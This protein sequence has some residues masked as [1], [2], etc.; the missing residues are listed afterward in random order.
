M[1]RSYELILDN[2]SMLVFVGRNGSGKSFALNS[3]LEHY[4]HNSLYISEEGIP[5][6]LHPKNSVQIYNDKYIYT[7]EKLR[8]VGKTETEEYEI[9]S[10]SL[11]II[12]YCRTVLKEIDKVKNKSQGQKKMASILKIFLSYNFNNI[13]YILFDE[14][15]NFLDE[16]YLRVVARLIQKL[17]D[18]QFK[19]RIATHNSTLMVLL[20]INVIDIRFF[21][22]REIITITHQ[23]MKDL[24][25]KSK[26]M[27]EHKRLIEKLDEDSSIAYKLKIY[28]NEDLFC[29]YIDSHIK[30]IE[31][32]QTIFYPNIIIVEGISDKQALK[33]IYHAFNETTILFV[34]DGKA[35][36]IFFV[37]LFNELKKDI[38]VIIDEDKDNHMLA[39]TYVLQAMKNIKLIIHTPDM[40]GEYGLDLRAVA[41]RYGMSNKVRKNNNGWLKQIAAYDYFKDD[42]NQTKLLDKV[43]HID[44]DEYEFS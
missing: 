3:I 6:V 4:K 11:D 18:G 17:Q 16:S 5:K 14:P 39:I 30:D 23:K 32:Y 36:I 9:D 7:D 35:W 42:V 2:S 28:E 41:D 24:L 12:E 27:I 10:R 8:G 22:D 34:T 43:F 13:D 25:K 20:N 29:N 31:F 40:E 1:S 37:L 33:S 21:K 26:E 15:E 38:K 19:V 44:N